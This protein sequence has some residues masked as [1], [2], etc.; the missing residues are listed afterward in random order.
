MSTGYIDAMDIFSVR[1]YGA[2]PGTTDS[3]GLAIDACIN[4]AISAGSK[5]VYFPTGIY[6]TTALSSNINSVYFVGDN[7][8]FSSNG[9]TYPIGQVFG[10]D[11]A[12]FGSSGQ[13]LTMD[14]G[15]PTWKDPGSVDMDPIELLTWV[16]L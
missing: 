5:I 8:S 9:S 10:C 12:E 4:A 13:V 3:Q 16:L 2:V 15:K 14:A 6:M 7:A 11:N 1:R